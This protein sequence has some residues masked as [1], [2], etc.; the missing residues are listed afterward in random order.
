M[1]LLGKYYIDTKSFFKKGVKKINEPFGVFLVNGRMGTGKTFFVVKW[2]FENFK[3]YKIKTNIQSLDIPHRNIE[4]FLKLDSIF[5]DED[6]FTIYIIDEIGKRYTKDSKCDA[7][8]YN[9]LQHSRKNKRIIFLIHQE[10]LQVPPWLRGPVTEV[11]TTKKFVPLL[12]IYLSFRGLPYLDDESKEWH[13][14]YN[15]LY[16]YKRTKEIA[17]LYNTFE[18]VT[19]L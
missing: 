1:R 4:H 15:S 12:P 7:D 2:V 8:F 5:N 3:D 11:I 18:M 13:V 16:I 14:E 17:C 6:E 9:F 19:T 10:Y